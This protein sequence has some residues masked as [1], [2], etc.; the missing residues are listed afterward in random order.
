VDS[1]PCRRSSLQWLTNFNVEAFQPCIMGRK[2]GTKRTASA[3]RLPTNSRGAGPSSTAGGNVNRETRSQAAAMANLTRAVGGNGSSA[4]VNSSGDSS[5]GISQN[6]GQNQQSGQVVG[7]VAQNS[8][9]NPGND[10]V[11]NSPGSSSAQYQSR[12]VVSRPANSSA[13]GENQRDSNPSNSSESSAPLGALARP[14]GA[15]ASPS[16]SGLSQSVAANSSTQSA[17]S[18]NNSRAQEQL[19]YQQPPWVDGANQVNQGFQGQIGQARSAGYPGEVSVTSPVYASGLGNAIGHNSAAL[20]RG[21][22]T[23]NQSTSGGA[24]RFFTGSAAGESNNTVFNSFPIVNHV[25]QPAQPIDIVHNPLVSIC[26]P[27]GEQLTQAIISKIVNS[28]FVEFASLLDKIDN[29]YD[30]GCSEGMSLSVSQG[31]QVVW[32]E[33]TKNKRTVTSIHAWTDAFLVF[34]AV[35][36][37]AHPGRTQELFKY[38]KLIRT[39]AAKSEGWRTYDTQFRMRQQRQPHR[40]W[41]IIDGEL[42]TI[43]VMTPVQRGAQPSSFRAASQ[44]KNQSGGGRRAP[45]C[46]AFNGVTSCSRNT[47]KFDHR[48]SQ[49]QGF[50][51]GAHSCKQEPV[52]ESAGRGDFASY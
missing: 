2:R 16:V 6:I 5:S 1:G 8:R 49:C 24:S 28:E 10:G 12:N 37:E 4:V 15:L 25:I 47:C 52:S 48:C 31:G 29:G 26:S 11:N 46:Y 32:V 34:S 41:G 17:Q 51:H 27:L 20:Q 13:N 18:T 9:Q 50:G 30:Q 36:L 23:Q 38:A 33:N 39:A 40:S 7:A 44:G 19:G 21:N 42:W 3:A 14:L 35:Y 45:L 22:V 43:Y